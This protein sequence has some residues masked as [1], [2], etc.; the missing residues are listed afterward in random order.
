MNVEL[1]KETAAKLNRKGFF[2][3]CSLSIHTTKDPKLWMLF[4]Y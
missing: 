4:N 1:S 3:Y 2:T